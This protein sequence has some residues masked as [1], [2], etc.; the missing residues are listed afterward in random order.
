M[1]GRA[2]FGMFF[3]AY[4]FIRPARPQ[5]QS[6]EA[7]MPFKGKILVTGINLARFFHNNNLINLTIIPSEPG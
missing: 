1:L 5:I 7:K 2:K 6:G 4:K 3:W